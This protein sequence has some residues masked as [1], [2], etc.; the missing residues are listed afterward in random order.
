MH[1]EVLQEEESSQETM[2]TPLDETMAQKILKALD[3]HG[4]AL[5]KIRSCLT[6]LEETKLKKAEHVEVLDDEEVEDWDGSDK[7]DFERNK[8]FKK[9]MAKTIAMREKMEKMQLAFRKA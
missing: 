1:Q 7:A 2:S 4:D 5:K 6:K 9:L 8:Q 3:K